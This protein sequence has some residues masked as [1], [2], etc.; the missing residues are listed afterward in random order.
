ML[1]IGRMAA[2]CGLTVS[3]LRFYDGAG[4]LVPAWVDPVTGYRHY[5]RDQV[6]RARLVARLRRVGLPLAEIGQVLR[7]RDDRAAAERVLDRHLRR[8]EDGLAD[9]RRE[10]SAA[11]RILDRLE[12]TMSDNQS[13]PTTVTV[14]AAD[15]AAALRA[16]RPVVSTDPELP[17]LNGV[18]LDVDATSLHVVATDRYRMTVC[19]PP[20]VDLGGP[21]VGVLVGVEFVDAALA[22]L[23]GVTAPVSVRVLG[24]DVVLE[25]A[26]RT[27]RTR[28]L[29]HEYPDFRRVARRLGGRRVR[30]DVGR[31]RAQLAGAPARTML[32]EQD[33]VEYAVST[34]AVGGGGVVAGEGVDGD[35]DTV[36]IVV[37]REYLLQALDTGDRPELLLDLDGPIQPLAI[38]RPDDT[39]TV[40]ILMPTRVA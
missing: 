7:C 1:G 10:L 15:L 40:S 37:N 31:L 30:F 16:V 19:A 29:D 6:G 21:A 2:E 20:V 35:A 5:R 4:I 17:V 39:R 27:V 25:V 23:G 9:A 38:R 11:R 33:G 34:L 28:R 36:R 18:L 3:A 32:R 22:A 24:D 14:S 8:L 26:G 12:N 13:T